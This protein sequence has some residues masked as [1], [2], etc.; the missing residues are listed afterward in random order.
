MSP[1]NNG[2]DGTPPV[3]KVSPGIAINAR[4]QILEVES[5]AES[6]SVELSRSEPEDEFNEDIFK[7]CAGPPDTKQVPN[8][9]GMYLLVIGPA[10]VYQEFAPKSGLLAA[11]DQPEC[12]RRYVTEGIQFR[13]VEVGASLF[14]NV[15][16][17]IK[18]SVDSL[19]FGS[20]PAKVGE[21]GRLSKLQ[22]IFAHLCYDSDYYSNGA[23][24]VVENNADLV[25]SFNR[26]ILRE[27]F[28]AG[29]GLSDCD[30]PIAAIYWTEGG[31]AFLDDWSVRRPLPDL[32]LRRLQ[33]KS[34]VFA[35]MQQFQDQLGKL[36]DVSNLRLADYFQYLPPVGRIPVQDSSYSSADG[37]RLSQFFGSRYSRLPAVINASQVPALIEL[38]SSYPPLQLTQVGH[39]NIF[40]VKENVENLLSGDEGQLYAYF[41][42]P[43][44]GYRFCSP[45][46]FFAQDEILQN[47]DFLSLFDAAYAAY[48]GFENII[49]RYMA[50]QEV[51][52]NTGILLGFKAIDQVLGA[53]E[54]VHAILR[55]GCL[56]NHDLY[57]NFQRVSAQQQNFV[58]IWREILSI[59]AA[60][61]SAPLTDISSLSSAA[62][63]GT[64]DFVKALIEVI[65]TVTG[66]IEEPV[67]EGFRGLVVALADHDIAS[68]YLTQQKINQSFTVSLGAGASGVIGLSYVNPPVS[69]P[70]ATGGE[71]ALLLAGDY[72]FGFELEARVTAPTR[73]RL[74]PRLEQFGWEAVLID[75]AN[76]EMSPPYYLHLEKSDNLPEPEVHAI[77]V[78]VSVPETG[79]ASAVLVFD[80]AEDPSGGGIPPAQEIVS[81][82]RGESIP[83]PDDRV[84]LMFSSYGE[85]PNNATPFGGGIAI[86]RSIPISVSFVVSSQIEGQFV[87]GIEPADGGAWQMLQISGA[88]PGTPRELEFDLIGAPLVRTIT[89]PMLPGDNVDSNTDLVLTLKSREGSTPPVDPAFEEI[90]RLPVF[91]QD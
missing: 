85:P 82:T 54:S 1:E 20:T 40:L 27:L 30:V 41:T 74:Q 84:Q 5:E 39:V 9:A 55:S 4:G 69:P 53:L 65:E 35:S 76:A 36:E 86:P 87:I 44:V 67:Y 71:S 63:S 33:F 8:G 79:E 14:A 48:R 24:D 11:G 47:D 68:A 50:K 25:W 60:A 29:N 89:V 23:I 88:A 91:I 31:I 46:R 80:V 43:E 66:L 70:D 58:N 10:A 45:P 22:N 62:R 57:R 64:A 59:E 78:K 75:E 56:T 6:I 7:A 38:S 13:L 16:D 21:P 15:P 52:T 51:G 42:I 72:V 17:D 37:V 2:A 49:L 32:N 18:L 90:Y 73:V 19:L 3:V 34:L 77:K 12:G 83:F 81:L 26:G 28:A 61:V